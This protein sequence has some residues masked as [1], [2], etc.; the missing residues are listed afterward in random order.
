MVAPQNVCE[1][2]IDLGAFL[3]WFKAKGIDEMF[4]RSVKGP[5]LGAQ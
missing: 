1:D 2:F 4:G 5:T 3:R